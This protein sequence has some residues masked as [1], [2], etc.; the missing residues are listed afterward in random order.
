LEAEVEAKGRITIPARLR[1][2]LGIVK[3]EKLEISSKEGAII[4]KRKK[5]MSVSDM[6]GIL[7]RSTVKLEDVE[8]AL[9]KE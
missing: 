5:Q 2:D 7:G 4:L 1:R 6:K 3:G 9:G 8:D